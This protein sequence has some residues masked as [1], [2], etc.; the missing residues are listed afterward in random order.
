MIFFKNKKKNCSKG[1]NLKEFIK[2][3]NECKRKHVFMVTQ[4]LQRKL[5]HV[6]NRQNEIVESKDDEHPTIKERCKFSH[7]N[8]SNI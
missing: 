3:S 5:D 4:S 8:K 1:L 6:G 2:K 7:L